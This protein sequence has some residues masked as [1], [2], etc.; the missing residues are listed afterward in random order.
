MGTSKC[1]L[2]YLWADENIEVPTWKGSGSDPLTNLNLVVN[3]S[4][5]VIY[6]KAFCISICWNNYCDSPFS[7]KFDIVARKLMLLSVQI[8]LF[9]IRTSDVLCSMMDTKRL[10]ARGNWEHPLLQYADAK[11]FSITIVRFWKAEFRSV[12]FS[13]YRIDIGDWL[14]GEFR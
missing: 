13:W 12:I 2:F 6:A 4:F 10:F 14:P 3:L 8:R 7:S 1:T 11:Y 9:L 5:V